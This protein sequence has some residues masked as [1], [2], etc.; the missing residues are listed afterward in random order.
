MVRVKA[1]RWK[2]LINLKRNNNIKPLTNEWKGHKLRIGQ[3]GKWGGEVYG[4]KS[5][6]KAVTNIIIQLDVQ[7]LEAKHIS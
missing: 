1:Q 4:G 5:E 2:K 6:N 7:G 3:L